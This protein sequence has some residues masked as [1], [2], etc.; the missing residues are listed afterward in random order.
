MIL[1]PC[2]QKLAKNQFSPTHA[3]GR[4][5]V[6]AGGVCGPQELR[7]FN[8]IRLTLFLHVSH[9]QMYYTDIIYVTQ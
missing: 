4:H 8:V 1:F 5:L 9:M 6:G 2:D 7:F 3:Q